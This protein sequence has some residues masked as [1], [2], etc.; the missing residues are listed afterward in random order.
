MKYRID[1]MVAKIAAPVLVLYDGKEQRF[2]NGTQAAAA[3][4]DKNYLIDSINAGNGIIV[5]S[6]KEND[7]I[8]N[9]NW[10]G[11]QKGSFF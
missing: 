1:Q 2:D 6:L 11:E 3:E 10:F 7:M 8:N 5:V 4:Y 9:V